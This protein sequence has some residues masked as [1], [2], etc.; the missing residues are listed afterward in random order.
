[1]E[2]YSPVAIV[3]VLALVVYV[4]MGLQVARAR[5]RSGIKA[6]EMTGDPALERAIRV[7][8]NTLEWLPVF[9]AGLWLFA[10]YASVLGAA[11]L[12]VV[13][14]VGRLLYA[15]GYLADP[16][17]RELGFLIQGAA[18]A[19]LLLGALGKIVWDMA[20]AGA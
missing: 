17:K 20:N 13:W 12:G 9:L 6:P 18:S 1:M 15:R 7:H 14:I 16:G 3:T 10:I 8:I 5:S 2:T 11:G 19:V 4:G